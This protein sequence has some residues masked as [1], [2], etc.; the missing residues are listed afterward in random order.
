MRPEEFLAHLDELP[1]RSHNAEL[2][3]RGLAQTQAAIQQMKD[4][5]SERDDALLLFARTV[6]ASFNYA[7]ALP[8]ATDRFGG[9]LEPS[10][11]HAGASSLRSRG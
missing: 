7:S 11:A 1:E 10:L 6:S 3:R 5:V 4:G 2:L 8:G 9:V